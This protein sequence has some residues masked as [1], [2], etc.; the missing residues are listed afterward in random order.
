MKLI[1]EL[2]A[3]KLCMLWQEFCKQL[4]QEGKDVN[5]T[6]L[7]DI[8]FELVEPFGEVRRQRERLKVC[9]HPSEHSSQTCNMLH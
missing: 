2:E 4:K 9:S 7:R 5:L 3:K 1:W 8:T 6:I